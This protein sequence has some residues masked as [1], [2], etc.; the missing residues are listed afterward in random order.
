MAFT[1]T[2]VKENPV[3][4][5]FC[6]KCDCFLV[7]HFLSCTWKCFCLSPFSL[8]HCVYIASDGGRVCRPLV[9][10]DRGISR[11]KDYHMKELQVL[12]VFRIFPYF[13][14]IIDLFILF[15]RH[16]KL[17]FLKLLSLYCSLEFVLLMIFYGMDWLNILMSMKRT[18]HWFVTLLLPC[19]VCHLKLSYSLSSTLM[20]TDS[21]VWMWKWHG[22]FWKEKGWYNPHRDWAFDNF[23]CLCRFNSFS[24]PQPIST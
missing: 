17:W 16:I 24:S 20:L 13:G 2:S 21:T 5:R 15:S 6:H 14:L 9:I 7:C 22:W 8:K 10:A 4:W 19:L 11:I 1:Y 18:M 12:C 23:R 3:L